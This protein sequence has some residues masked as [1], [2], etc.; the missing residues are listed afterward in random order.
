MP[1]PPVIEFDPEGNVVQVWGGPGQGYDWVTSE[2]GIYVDPK[3]FV[4][5][6]GNGEADGQLLKFTREGRFVL[7][8]ADRPFRAGCCQQRHDAPGPSG[9]CDA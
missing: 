2:H 3:G 7:Q 9:R 6:G 1:A 5:V 4:W 8:I